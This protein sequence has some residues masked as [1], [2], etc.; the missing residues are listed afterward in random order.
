M[1]QRVSVIIPSYN[2]GDR[3]RATIK[4]L[5]G[6]S[7]IPEQVTVVD[8]SSRD[9]FTESLKALSNSVAVIREPKG[10]AAAARRAGL[11]A[12]RGDYIAF[13]DADELWLPYHL[14]LALASMAKC[15]DLYVVYGGAALIIDPS[16][17][18]PAIHDPSRVGSGAELLFANQ[19]TTSAVLVTANLRLA[20]RLRRGL[21]SNEDMLL[22]WIEMFMNGA[23]YCSSSIPSGLYFDRPWSLGYRRP[24]V[25]DLKTIPLLMREIGLGHLD[26][27]RAC[28]R[29][30]K[31]WIAVAGSELVARS[32]RGSPSPLMTSTAIDAPI[33]RALTE[34]QESS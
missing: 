25:A 3:L 9:R 15:S 22:S 10:G 31:R 4:S 33:G 34:E 5:L 17:T 29:A 6:Q 27:V 24:L 32:P 23:A 2:A 13:L 20:V 14:D 12:A 16:G 28:A 26:L 1:R 8:N 19:L 30:T 7:H 18:P 11:D 21:P